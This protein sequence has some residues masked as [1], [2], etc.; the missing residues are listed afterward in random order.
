[1]NVSDHVFSALQTF[2]TSVTDKMKAL[3]S[4]EPEDQLRSPFE[5]FLGGLQKP[6]G[7][8]IVI[9]GEAQVERLG[10]PDFAVHT[11]GLLCGY[12]EL[13]APG[14][15]ARPERYKGHDKRQW[16]RFK[17]LPNILYTDGNEWAV[18]RDGVLEGRLVRLAGDVSQ[19]GKRGVAKEDAAALSHLLG[20][21][22]EWTPIIP[23]GSRQIAHL[24]APLCRMLRDEV[25]E[26]VKAPDSPLKELAGDWRQLLFPE[27][28][29]QEFADAYA[30]TVTFALL[31]AR[32]EGADAL[33][34]EK[35]IKTLAAGHALLS[36]ALEVLTDPLAK[37]DL[38]AS[39]ELLKRV[40]AEI[41]TTRLDDPA[42]YPWLYFYE[43][44]LA[45]YDPRLR[46]DAG[47]YYTPIEVVHAQV[48]LI[49]QLLSNN[50]G[51]P[52]GF[53]D[54]G[55]VVLDPATGT[56]TYLLA[57]IQH[58]LNRVKQDQGPGA[59][60]GQ[61]AGL[62]AR[63]YGFENM[64]GPY[65]V[66]Q[67]RV[68]RSLM[69]EGARL[70]KGGVGI[71][72]TDTLES[73]HAE[74]SWAG[75]YYG[76]MADQHK[77]ALKVK[78]EVPVLVCLG[79]PP[80]DRH[81]AAEENKG[82][83]GWVRWGDPKMVEVGKRSILEDFLQPARLA[84]HGVHLKNLYNLYVYF[85]RW[86]LW[87]VFEH[88]QDAPPGPGIV[89]FITASSYL[90]GD[91]FVGMR[92][93]MRRLC[94]E[95][96]IIDLGGEGRG[97]RQEENV[98]NIQTPVAIA[99]AVRY[100]KAKPKKAAKV[101]YSR[102]NGTREEKLARLEQ[103]K[104]F[105]SLKWKTCP[106]AWEAP[107]SPAGKGDFFSWP[108]L[109]DIF[110]WQHSGVQFKRT[111]PIAPDKQTLER[112]WRGLLAA[113]DKGK[114]FRETGGRTVD[115]QY[116]VLLGAH[117]APSLSS[118]PK[119]APPPPMVKY[120]Y[121]SF[122]KQLTFADNR[123]ADRPRPPIWLALGHKQL[124]L[125]SLLYD[126]LGEG[127]VLTCSAVVPDLHYFSGRGA[128]DILPLFRDRDATKPNLTPGLL[129]CL[130]PA[131]GSTL[132]AEDLAAYLYG[133]LAQPA[134]TSRFTKDLEKR[135]VRVP[136]TKDKKLF[137]K[138]REVGARLLWLHTYGER[139]VP[140]GQRPGQVPSG[141]A[142]CHVAISDA[143]EEY[144]ED[145]SYN[146]PTR[147]LHVGKGEFKPV[148]PEVFQFEVS[149][150]KVVQSWLKYRMKK[151]AGRKSSPLDDIRPERWTAEFTTEL[152]NLLWVLEATVAEYPRMA[153]LLEAVVEGDTFTEDELPAVPEEAREAPKVPKGGSQG[154]Q[155]RLGLRHRDPGYNDND[156]G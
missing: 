11:K 119:D 87:K 7:V 21:F 88:P 14:K 76:P 17:D 48:R 112:R 107:F 140:Q 94:D 10:R 70:P 139:F 126:V 143:P 57:L 46:K 51:R 1:M 148:A 89:S 20:V 103:V 53:A 18:Y 145:Y 152:L 12:V 74:P 93:H 67:L 134:F 90:E 65:A 19:D 29:D 8:K 15:G 25:I 66:A 4:G 3:G 28:S 101:H 120:A 80:Y 155:G 153:E 33:N 104:G 136:L 36:K 154:A 56:G 98:F 83:G 50:L 132:S 40:I 92:E 31:L 41:P 37:E 52:Q 47:A 69:D 43:D 100:D 131:L 122:D 111:W 125:A 26:A 113:S 144:P 151:G 124:Y 45:A 84:G 30:Q 118:L 102:I 141:S 123:F 23:K 22:L 138:V 49:D 6:L 146:E 77:K 142:K 85:W 63:V 59:V 72:L 86:A 35:A 150:L 137:A 99:V 115:G 64:V 109:T 13:K 62:A 133:V 24:L 97:S 116:T 60:A 32:S 128:K 117:K 127:P 114:A 149:G 27:A 82:A 54:S 105:T 68:S 110:P 108:L 147:T 135:E 55:V 61:A 96:W 16:E 44:F 156:S 5:A 130:S 71:F 9:K 95:I 2:A 58:T 73:P 78:K 91:A 79:N 38:S 75:A 121:R 39:L 129:E 81:A 34:L 106:E 42:D